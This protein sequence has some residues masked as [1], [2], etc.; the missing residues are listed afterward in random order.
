MGTYLLSGVPVSIKMR[1]MVSCAAMRSYR[2]QGEPR[3]CR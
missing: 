3:N 2:L 1:G